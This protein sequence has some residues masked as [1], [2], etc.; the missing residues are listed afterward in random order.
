M[1][2]RL[3]RNGRNYQRGVE[4]FEFINLWDR[5]TRTGRREETYVNNPNTE[6]LNKTRDVYFLY[7]TS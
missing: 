7:K 3:R 1:E 2:T 4:G 6:S 5:E